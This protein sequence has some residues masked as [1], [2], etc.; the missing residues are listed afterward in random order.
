MYR[1]ILVPVDLDHP[2]DWRE[3][4]SAARSLA[5]CYSAK[6]TICSIV[7]DAHA[8]MHG[9][10]LP[11]SFEQLL[12]DTRARLEALASEVKADVNC[13]VEV[14]SGT[15]FGGILEVANRISADLIVI[16]SHR[17]GARDYV[18]AANAIRVAKRSPC[19]V[20][21]ARHGAA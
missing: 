6:V 20:L 14:A 21:I 9:E 13:A 4:L 19:S 2:A 16:G 7:S 1:N 18:L 17:P 10:W 15:I 11:I 12:F 3:A 5:K 8:I